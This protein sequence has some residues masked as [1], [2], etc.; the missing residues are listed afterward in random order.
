VNLYFGE[1]TVD[2]AGWKDQLDLMKEGTEY[3]LK[4]MPLGNP[5][6]FRQGVL[7]EAERSGLLALHALLRE[8]DPHQKRLGLR[9]VP[10]YTGDYLWLCQKHY[11][12]SQ[13]KIPERI[14]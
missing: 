4:D 11:E 9:R 14:E 7:S 10:T 13:S 2:A 3:L 12:Q 8:L 5:D 1:N 6:R